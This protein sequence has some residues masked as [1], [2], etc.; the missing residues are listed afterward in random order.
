M[1]ELLIDGKVFVPTKRAAAIT[2][3]AK[4]YI[5]QLCREGRIEAKL[6]GRS[7][8]VLETSLREHRFGGETSVAAIDEA[9]QEEVADAHVEEAVEATQTWQS[10]SYTPEPL[11][12]ILPAVHVQN[13]REEIPTSLENTAFH[14]D[15]V[16]EHAPVSEVQ[17]AWKEWFSKERPVVQEEGYTHTPGTVPTEELVEEPMREYRVAEQRQPEEAQEPEEELPVTEEVPIRLTKN[18]YGSMDIGYPKRHE[19]PEG[20]IL[21]ERR[22]KPRR[23]S[24]PQR[25]HKAAS[26]HTI[27][28][29]VLIGVM[30][31]IASVTVIGTGAFQV[32]SPTWLSSTPAIDFLAGVKVIDR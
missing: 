27:L 5:G 10:P 13:E 28:K 8:Y 1:D 7:W 32:F 2:G 14:E 24:A 3:Y 16:I 17:D 21:T 19:E 15:V 18:V 6:V 25:T 9:H 4:D 11:E 29:A 26:R 30:L 20:R 31:L 12:E 23:S 22:V